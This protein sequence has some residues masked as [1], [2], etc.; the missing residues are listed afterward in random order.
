MNDERFKQD[1]TA[2]EIVYTHAD[3]NKTNMGLTTW[4]N[5]P[6]GRILKSDVSIAKNYL[7]EKQIWQLEWTVTGYFT[8]MGC[9]PQ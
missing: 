4:K 2:A 9:C 1:Q 8:L 6:N 3:R 5:A 7:D